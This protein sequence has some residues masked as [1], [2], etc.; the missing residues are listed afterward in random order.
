MQ[1]SAPKD[2]L[3]T[4]SIPR[5]KGRAVRRATWQAGA[6]P[7]LLPSCIPNYNVIKQLFAEPEH[8]LRNTTERTAEAVWSRIGD[9]V[10]RF[11][12]GECAKPLQKL[13]RLSLLRPCEQGH[14]LCESVTGGRVLA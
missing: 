2:V 12:P 14:Y 11:P 1:T 10:D 13:V 8:L 4:D 7:L 6:R 5:H 3:L 9:L